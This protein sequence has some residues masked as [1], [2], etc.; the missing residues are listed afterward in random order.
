MQQKINYILFFG[1]GYLVGQ[2]KHGW[3]PFI[4]AVLFMV[5]DMTIVALISH[6]FRNGK[7]RWQKLKHEKRLTAND[8]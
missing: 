4:F 3:K 5:V 7:D 1:I 2:T 8:L 6:I